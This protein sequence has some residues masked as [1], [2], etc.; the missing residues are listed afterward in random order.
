LRQH[1]R[2]IS[3]L[4]LIPGTLNVELDAEVVLASTCRRL[5]AHE[6]SGPHDALLASCTVEG[7]RGVIIRTEPNNLRHGPVPPSILEIASD[8]HYRTLLKLKT[9]DLVRVEIDS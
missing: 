1:Y 5:R 6:W 7:R 4:E 9:G 2:C 3:G 8:S